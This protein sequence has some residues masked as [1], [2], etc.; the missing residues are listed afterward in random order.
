M[1]RHKRSMLDHFLF[2]TA[3]IFS[4]TFQ[5]I[6]QDALA[7]GIPRP[8]PTPIP[9]PVPTPKPTPVPTPTPTPTPTPVPCATTGPWIDHAGN[10]YVITL[11]ASNGKYVAAECGGDDVGTINANRDSAGEWETF[12]VSV[13]SNGN[14]SIRTTH[15]RY[16]SAEGGG[17]AD[18]HANRNAFGVWE[19]FHLEGDLIEG[20]VISLKTFDETH[21]LSARSDRNPPFVDA[22]SS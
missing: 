17:G 10:E 15:G 18:V 22:E 9:T 2:F 7:L 1:D 20:S 4:L 5:I 8:R 6:A 11:Q 21:Y 12:Y 19:T 13:Q 3:I 14:M 16:L